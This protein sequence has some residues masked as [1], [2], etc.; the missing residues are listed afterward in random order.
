MNRRAVEAAQAA[1]S[2]LVCKTPIIRSPELDRLAG[3]NLF[4]KAENLQRIGAFKARGAML[5]ISRLEPAVLERGIVTYSSG[6]HGQAVALAA[7]SFGTRATVVM[8]ENAPQVKIAAVRTLGAEVIFAGTTSTER[9]EVAES[10]GRQ[11]K[12]VVLPS[13]DHPDVI[14]G[15]GTA[16][17]EMLSQMTDALDALV[18][19]VGG[20]GLA[21]GASLALEGTQ[22]E[23]HTV[24]PIGCD[25]LRRS[26]LAGR[27]ESVEP[28]PT[29]A[30]GLK[31][32]KVGAHNFPI[33]QKRVCEAHTVSDEE[34]GRAVVAALFSAKMLLEPSGA[35]PLALALRGTLRNR[36]KNVGLLCSGGNIEPSV[37]ARL[38]AA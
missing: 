6:N 17:L 2:G 7:A 5:A 20:G 33:L 13:F 24:E 36:Y 38:I 27:P 9:Q 30:D 19:P 25:T 34:M 31:S 18:V 12:A 11:R 21:A 15:Q 3:A 14:L 16:T 26:L 37:L 29:I 8:P 1:L 28:A 35:A 22:V 23:L 32:V 10:L 4:L